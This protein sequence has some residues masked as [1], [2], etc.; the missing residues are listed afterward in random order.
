MRVPIA[1][2]YRRPLEK[3]FIGE[4]VISQPIDMRTGGPAGPISFPFTQRAQ[5]TRTGR[6]PPRFTRV[7]GVLYL[8]EMFSGDYR[9][10]E[11][12][13]LL[14]DNANAPLRLPRDVW[15]DIPVFSRNN[16]QWTWSDTGKCGV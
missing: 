14:I 7:S 10:I 2:D 6:E 12:L 11:H 16:G 9:S 8:G 13:A 15:K 1:L 4:T 3:A 5:L